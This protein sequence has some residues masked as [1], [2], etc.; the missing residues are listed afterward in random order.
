MANN[1]PTSLNTHKK[2]WANT[3]PVA[4]THPE[5]HND[6]AEA[7]EAIEAKVGVNGSAVQTSHDYKLSGV[8]GSDKAASK[9]AQDDHIADTD[10]PHGVTKSQIGL[11]SVDNTSDADKP[12]S[13]AQQAA[14]DLKADKS[15][16]LSDLG[17]VAAARDNLDV[18][19]KSEVGA[20]IADVSIVRPYDTIANIDTRMPLYLDGGYLKPSNAAAAGTARFLGFASASVGISVLDASPQVV[21]LSNAPHSYTLPAGNDRLIAVAFVGTA[22][23]GISASSYATSVEFNGIALTLGQRNFISDTTIAEVWYGYKGSSASPTTANVV[24][25]GGHGSWQG[26]IVTF[27]NVDQAS[28]VQ[29]AVTSANADPLT[30]TITP[31]QNASYLLYFGGFYAV[32]PGNG[33]TMSGATLDTYNGAAP[34]GDYPLYRRGH[35]LNYATAEQSFTIDGNNTRLIAIALE[36]LASSQEIEVQITGVVGGFSGL[37]EGEEYYLTNTTGVIGTTPGTNTVL[38]GKAISTTELLIVH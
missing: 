5:E 37:T 30:R 32:N 38:V 7:V 12:V 26:E 20:L 6:I 13:T 14:I 31:L 17:D 21:A 24:I 15:A 2:D 23:S 19:S 33:F 28:G 27:Q 4:D 1:F 9:A 34:S 11:G 3:T 25:T 8:T 22:A 16:N 36:L 18:Y 10:N 35:E 29:Q